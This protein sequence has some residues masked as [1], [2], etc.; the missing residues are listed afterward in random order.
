M[1]S[2]TLSVSKD[3]KQK[4][5]KHKE[6]RWSEIARQAIQERIE[7]LEKM[8]RLLEKSKLTERETISLGRKVNKSL[9]S[10]YDS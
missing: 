1:V 3:L 6:I 5:G 8:D 2:V 4:M 10:R 7:L 9:A